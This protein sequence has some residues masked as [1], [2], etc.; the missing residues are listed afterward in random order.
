MLEVSRLA[1]NEMERAVSLKV[2][3]FGSLRPGYGR[4]VIL[5]KGLKKCGVTISAYGPEAPV[6]TADDL[7]PAGR[8]LPVRQF[9][10]LSARS[11]GN[12][13]AQRAM[14]DYDLLLVSFLGHQDLP[15]LSI[16]AKLRGKSLV[17]DPFL[18]IYDTIVGDRNLIASGSLT[19]KL[20]RFGESLALK[21]PDIVIADTNEQARFYDKELGVDSSKLRTVYVGAD[22][23]YFF[24]REMKATGDTFR[25][26]FYGKYAPLHGVNRIVEAAHILRREAISFQL[27]GKG[28]TYGQTRELASKFDLTNIKFVDWVEYGE[29]PAEIAGSDVC[30]GI[31]G[32]TEKAKRVIPT[33]VFQCLAMKKPV[34]TSNTPA[35]REALTDHVDALLCDANSPERLADA[36][37]ELKSDEGLR[38]RIAANGFRTFTDR[39]S[40]ECVGTELLRIFQ[41]LW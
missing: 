22:E 4:N 5:V 18:S 24:P 19:A 27:I 26:L 8:K 12:L 13:A 20:T 17:F 16:S 41:S 15:L 23:D 34:V 28:Q 14:E 30:L 35:A 33:K 32:D 36:I 1:L 6:F 25:V 29:L 31:F 39:F 3:F 21:L 10:R 7:I 37:L 38:N 2:S 11:L 9:F 40:T